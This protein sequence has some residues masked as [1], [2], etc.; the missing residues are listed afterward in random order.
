ML[1]G[2]GRAGQEHQIKSYKYVFII[3]IIG[4]SFCIIIVDILLME[5]IKVTYAC[6]KS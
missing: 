1:E 4:S 2:K 3:I 6:V 5:K